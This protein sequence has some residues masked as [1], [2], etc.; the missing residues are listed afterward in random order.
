M[1][2]YQLSTSAMQNPGYMGGVS[3]G[4]VALQ[5]SLQNGLDA[6]PQFLEVYEPDML[7]PAAQS[8]LASV[9]SQLAFQRTSIFV[10]GN[11]CTSCLI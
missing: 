3:D 11:G 4:A 2:G 1:I 6:H 5:M 9:A 10:K 7:A 8:E